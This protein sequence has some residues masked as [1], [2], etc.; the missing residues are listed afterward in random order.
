L[1]SKVGVSLLIG[2]VVYLI[3]VPVIGVSV[4]IG[5]IFAVVALAASMFGMGYTVARRR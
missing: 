1:L 2:L 3:L 5:L 4:V